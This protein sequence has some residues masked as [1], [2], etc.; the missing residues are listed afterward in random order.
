MKKALKWS[1]LALGGMLILVLAAAFILPIVFK[2][3]IKSAI[4][5]E[6]A[7]SV[8][9]DV[10][11]DA[12]NF[13]LSLFSNF[14]NI[15]VA[16]RD[17]GVLNRAPFAGE[18]LF[19]TERFEVEINLKDILFGDVLRLKGISL[20]RPIINISVLADGKANYDITF[21]AEDSLASEEGTG[22]FSFR[23]DHWEIVDGSLKYDDQSIPFF[24]ALSGLNHSGSGDFTQDI[25]DLKTKT[26]ADT[27]NIGYGGD[28]YVSDK[29]MEI[30][31]VVS[32][33][34][35]YTKYTF[36][37]NAAKIN[38]FAVRFDGWFKMNENDYAMDISFQSPDN[39]FRSLLSL[40][41]GMYTESFGS[42]ETNGELAF[43]GF[44]KG[45]YSDTQM[46]A[47]NLKLLVKD[48]M[49]KYPELPTPINNINV[50]LLVD[51][52][53]G[54]MDNTVIDLKKLHMDF[55]TNPV[56]AHAL[57]T[58]MYPTNLDAMVAAKLNLR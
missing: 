16:M 46:P 13:S 21:P 52:K 28:M 45:T 40:I 17:L 8:N 42:I 24:M 5:K 15:T 51:N 10:V 53:D 38:D 7:K 27:V 2:D 47:F 1:L 32:I 14:P 31:A 20:V 9:A 48:A 43:D 29:R 6:L 49:F 18:I 25:F 23:I 33:A 37:E 39:S 30:D 44:T 54:I 55:G 36:K 3:D 34:E 50:E 12:D 56:D 41:P 26:V 57:I 4:D 19:A 22:E 58:K 11:F 35:G